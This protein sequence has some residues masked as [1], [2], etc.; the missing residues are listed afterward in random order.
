LIRGDT[1]WT[2]SNLIIQAPAE[3]AAV[4]NIVE[5]I[6][7]ECVPDNTTTPINGVFPTWIAKTVEDPP[8]EYKNWISPEFGPGYLIEV[9]IGDPNSNGI[10]IFDAGIN[11]KGAYYFDYMSGVLN[12]TNYLD[13]GN[14][15]NVLPNELSGNN[16]WIRG[17]RYIGFV[18]ISDQQDGKFGN[19]Q[20]SRNTVQAINKDIDDNPVTG[21]VILR[22]QLVNGVARIQ[23]S[24]FSQHLF[25]SG[26]AEFNTAYAK[27]SLLATRE[28]LNGTWEELTLDGLAPGLTNRIFLENNYT[29]K[30]RTEITG[31]LV[32][33][34]D[35]AIW[36]LQ[37]L[38]QRGAN[39][40]TTSIIGSTL[41][42]KVAGSSQTTVTI[43]IVNAGNFVN[44]NI[45]KIKTLGNTDWAS[46]AENYAM[47]FEVGTV[48][49]A[50]GEGSGTGDA[51]LYLTPQQ[52]LDLSWSVKAE[53]DTTN[54]LI[55]I[56]VKGP[57]KVDP[58]DAN[59]NI[60]WFAAI[61]ILEI[62]Q[63]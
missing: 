62:Y 35:S 18:G 39:A 16:I 46:I 61:N 11:D 52:S 23:G 42:E 30:I 15:S 57:D 29:Y 34:T 17:Y 13:N 19:L 7:V 10:R 43:L 20:L 27:T 51:Y 1:I 50:T 5:Y 40:S 8:V 58:G 41:T 25:T 63:I 9:Y 3:P 21:D 33:G 37:F 26:I 22:P 2:Q 59:K 55:Q 4:D 44:G 49:T 60:K 24:Q 54:G 38:A 47:D 14:N 45:Y 53:A 32:G 48:F 28:T 36:N 6:L 12:F 56:M 31:K